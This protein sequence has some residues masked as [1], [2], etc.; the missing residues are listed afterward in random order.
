MKGYQHNSET[1]LM[2]AFP[3]R[4]DDVVDDGDWGE[5]NSWWSCGVCLIWV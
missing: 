1:I 5:T 3:A 2:H 4:D